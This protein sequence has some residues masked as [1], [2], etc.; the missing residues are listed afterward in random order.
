M[1]DFDSF[2]ERT[3]GGCWLWTGPTEVQGYG[4]YRGRKAHRVAFEREHGSLD[5]VIMVCH[6]CDVRNCVNPAHLYA[7]D[8]A[9]NAA[10]MVARGRVAPHD[11]ENNGRA[12][13][14]AAQVAEIK[15]LL[16]APLQPGRRRRP[17]GTMAGLASLYGVDR[18][19]L[20]RIATG[21][22]WAA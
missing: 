13:L 22:I 1:D 2:V 11:G 10:D 6:H 9:T 20:H 19:I 12:K 14:T 3:A 15:A 18:T 4:T 5:G 8:A 21:K 17:R 7:G 16:G